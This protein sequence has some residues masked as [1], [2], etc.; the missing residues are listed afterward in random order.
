MRTSTRAEAEAQS[1]AAGKTLPSSLAVPDSAPCRKDACAALG[2]GTHLPQKAADVEQQ[3][4][5]VAM[6]ER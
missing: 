4:R 6:E 5:L 1:S 3:M 2:T